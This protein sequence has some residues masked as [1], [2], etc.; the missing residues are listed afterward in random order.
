L[1]HLV[2]H[3][4]EQQECHDRDSDTFTRTFRKIQTISL[5]S[6]FHSTKPPY[7]CDSHLQRSIGLEG[8]AHEYCLE[9]ARPVRS[10][11]ALMSFER[12]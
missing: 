12:I 8:E 11:S 7:V 5:Q 4:E 1:L 9:G 3:E 10:A 6:S 2:L